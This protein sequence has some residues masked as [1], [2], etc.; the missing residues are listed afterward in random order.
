MESPGSTFDPHIVAFFFV[1]YVLIVGVVLLNVVVAVLLDKFL[2]SIQ[3]HQDEQNE[4]KEK[5]ERDAVDSKLGVLVRGPIDPL[6]RGLLDFQCEQELHANMLKLYLRIDI[7]ES[8]TVTHEE[9]NEGLKKVDKSLH[10]NKEEFAYLMKQAKL[11]CTQN[12][13]LTY[14]HFAQMILSE[15][16][17]YTNRKVIYAF[18]HPQGSARDEQLF[19]LRMLTANMEHMS[20]RIHSLT[21]QFAASTLTF[22]GR[23]KVVAQMMRHPMVKCF[24]KWKAW[25]AA[26][27]THGDGIE[28]IPTLHSGPS[29]QDIYVKQELMETALATVTA[30]LI[31]HKTALA[32]MT[33][34]VMQIQGSLHTTKSPVA[35]KERAEEAELSNQKQ[36]CVADL[37]QQLQEQQQDIQQLQAE[38]RNQKQTFVQQLQ[39]Q[40]KDADRLLAD[41]AQIAKA[42]SLPIAMLQQA[43][44]SCNRLQQA[45]TRGEECARQEAELIGQKQTC[46]QQP[47]EQ[48]QAA[49]TSFPP[50]DGLLPKAIQQV[51]FASETSAFAPITC[52]DLHL[53]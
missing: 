37:K 5:K 53:D 2:R 4:I 22:K 45:T 27:S 38:L 47:P 19:A 16:R 49:D 14:Q 9:I 11:P 26:L 40:H 52:Y 28:S 34:A 51:R 35:T 36:T 44:T 20:E 32:T 42:D 21:P 29:L 30:A 24:K 10:I 6:L 17:N 48:Q 43:A 50:S 23:A 7:D 25:M 12:Q 18:N 13:S 3:S 1:S 39:E 8:G 46:L 31:E 15:M 41:T 33:A